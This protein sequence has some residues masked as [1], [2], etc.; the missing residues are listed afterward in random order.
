MSINIPPMR[1]IT[2][3]WELPTAIQEACN[4]YFLERLS[5]PDLANSTELQDGKLCINKHGTNFQ[6]VF[7]LGAE[8]IYADCLAKEAKGDPCIQKTFW[9]SYRSITW[10]WNRQEK[11][12]SIVL[13]QAA[14]DKV[15]SLSYNYKQGVP[16]LAPVPTPTPEQAKELVKLY[17][18]AF[19][20]TQLP[21]LTDGRVDFD[22][23]AEQ[24]QELFDSFTDP[25]KKPTHFTG[26]IATT[27]ADKVAQSL[28]AKDKDS[29]E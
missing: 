21:T 27:Y 28:E 14:R 3:R 11:T 24:N 19:P 2:S 16:N 25:A 23:L 9:L 15:R 10:S 26:L 13:V 8:K 4:H 29:E 12:D 7:Q 1:Y 17:R 6:I 5:F 20:V 18:R 22:K